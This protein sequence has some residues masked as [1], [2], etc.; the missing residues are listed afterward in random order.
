M[1]IQLL[2][3]LCL[4]ENDFRGG[5][6]RVIAIWG[7]MVEASE[8]DSDDSSDE[9][10]CESKAMS[11]TQSD[12]KLECEHHINDTGY[13]SLHFKKRHHI[14]WN[15][16]GV[17]ENGEPLP[18]LLMKYDDNYKCYISVNHTEDDDPQWLRVL[19]KC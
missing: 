9:D 4:K 15:D 3:G 10:D 14:L 1:T 17:S 19:K 7:S 2:D 13:V 11:D 8:S 5:D 12:S 16:D 6:A 18:P